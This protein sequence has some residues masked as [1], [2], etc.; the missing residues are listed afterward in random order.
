VR[1]AVAF[2]ERTLRQHTLTFALEVGRYLFEHVYQ[3]DRELFH[4]GGHPWQTETIRQIAADP[5]VALQPQFL[6]RSIH[7]YLAR[8]R[9]AAALPPGENLPDLPVSAWNALWP[10]ES[11]ESALV[12]VA[13]WA[14]TNRV[15]VREVADTAALVE[16]YLAAGGRLE[17]LL[18]TRSKE[19]NTPYRRLTRILDVL[20]SLLPPSTSSSPR[21]SPS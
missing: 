2:I 4:N 9:T 19:R 1:D 11:N 6:Y 21:S 8:E 20:D 17:D 3:A 14:A 15:P 7:A 13:R 18:P 16:P 12:P 5:R 10:I